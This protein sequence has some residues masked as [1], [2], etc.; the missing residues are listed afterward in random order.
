MFRDIINSKPSWDGEK[1][2]KPGGSM[3][4]QACIVKGNVK[5]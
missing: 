4:K 3:Y 1:R 2:R 5:P